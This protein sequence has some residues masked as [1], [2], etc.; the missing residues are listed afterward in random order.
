MNPED[1]VGWY[2][3]MAAKYLA[4]K[5]GIGV[6][7]A[8]MILDEQRRELLQRQRAARNEMVRKFNEWSPTTDDR[9]E[10]I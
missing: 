9:G 4:E 5:A 7:V 1:E 8:G 6:R 3:E 2:R 10:A